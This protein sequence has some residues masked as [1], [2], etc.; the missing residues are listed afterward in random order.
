M[1]SFRVGGK[2][3][4]TVPDADHLR[5]MLDDA[6]IQAAVA[7]DPLVCEPH[8]WGRRLA[9]VVVNTRKARPEVASDLVKEAWRGKAPKR[10]ADGFGQPGAS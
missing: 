5:I 9:C 7:E 4:A 6:G 10:L 2:I 8:Y 1:V 3:F